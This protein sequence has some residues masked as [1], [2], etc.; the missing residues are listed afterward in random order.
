MTPA[1]REEIIRYLSGPRNYAKGVALYERHGFNR[2]FKRRFM[3]E[4]NECTRAMLIEELRKL[5]GLTE[6]E[7]KRLPRKASSSCHPVAQQKKMPAP[8]PKH[9]LTSLKLRD[10]FPFLES[11]ECPNILKIVVADMIT[12]YKTYHTAF[13]QLQNLSDDKAAEAF[14]LAGTVVESYLINRE[15]LAE[16][17]HFQNTGNLLGKA[18]QFREMDEVED[19]ASLSDMELMRKLN[20]AKANQ[21]KR[22]KELKLAEDSGIDTSAAVEALDRWTATRARI[23]AEI[24]TRKKK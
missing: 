19:M 6:S 8:I 12:A 17:E 22:K 3:L 4:E 24:N 15:G 14:A 9:S 5:A 16:L 11:P 18:K 2:M 20:S 13:D 21:S 10:R 7:L 1:E 23:E